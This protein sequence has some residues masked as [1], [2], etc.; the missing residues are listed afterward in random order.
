MLGS[1]PLECRQWK[2]LKQGD[3]CEL[4]ASLNYKDREKQRDNQMFSGERWF[5]GNR[6]EEMVHGGRVGEA[7]RKWGWVL[8]YEVGDTGSLSQCAR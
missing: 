1:S 2:N 8:G 5:W 4:Q 3:C 6:E 7:I